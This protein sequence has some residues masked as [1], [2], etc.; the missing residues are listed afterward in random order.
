MN[1]RHIVVGL[2]LTLLVLVQ[3]ACDNATM[4]PFPGDQGAYSAAQATLQAGPRQA[5]E[6]SYQATMVSLNMDQAAKC[7]GA[8]HHGL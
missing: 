7:R 8:D 1:K 2:A 4:T 6:L 5:M 3:L